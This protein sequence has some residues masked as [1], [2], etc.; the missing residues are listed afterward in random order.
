MDHLHTPPIHYNPFSVR[1]PTLPKLLHIFAKNMFFCLSR[2]KI[3]SKLISGWSE[4]HRIVLRHC[5]IVKE[6]FEVKFWLLRANFSLFSSILVSFTPNFHMEN[7]PYRVAIFRCITKLFPAKKFFL[8][9]E[10]KIGL[11]SLFRLV[12]SFCKCIYRWFR[13]NWR[14]KKGGGELLLVWIFPWI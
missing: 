13:E 8:G 1:R 6:L 9:I 2:S 12:K 10:S 14:M 5:T 11:V 3:C 7:K 4:L